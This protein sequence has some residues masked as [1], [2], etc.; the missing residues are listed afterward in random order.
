MKYCMKKS[1]VQALYGLWM[2]PTLRDGIHFAWN[3]RL[4]RGEVIHRID[5]K[6]KEGFLHEEGV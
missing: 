4:T 2:L 6:A 5:P 1:E 3:L